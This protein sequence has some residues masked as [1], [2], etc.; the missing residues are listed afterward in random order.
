[1]IE[2]RELLMNL[3]IVNLDRQY[4]PITQIYRLTLNEL[5]AHDIE[6]KV[7]QTRKLSTRTNDFGARQGSRYGKIGR[8]VASPFHRLLK[9]C[10]QGSF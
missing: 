7:R 3:S 6:P 10:L 8:R 2:D 9:G 1:L 4:E 5:H